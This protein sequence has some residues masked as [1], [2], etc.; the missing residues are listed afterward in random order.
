[1]LVVD[2]AQSLSIELLEEVRLLANFETAAHKLLSVILAGQPELSVRLNDPALR[3]L[4]QRV[5]LRCELKPLTLQETATYLAGRIQAAGGQGAQVFTRDAVSLIHE[6]SAGIPRT[7][8]VLADNALVSGFALEQRPVGRH[9]V[10]DVCRDFDLGQRR[11]AGVD[12]PAGFPT[13]EGRTNGRQNELPDPVARPAAALASPRR[14]SL[15]MLDQPFPESPRGDEAAAAAGPA[16][17]RRLFG[18][19]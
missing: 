7:I 14:P 11:E 12:A 2:E 3:Q 18:I 6:R 19:F 4:K 9:I 8:S 15:L 5:A 16:R 10:L 17:R 13:G 1:M